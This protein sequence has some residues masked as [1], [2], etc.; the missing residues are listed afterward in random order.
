MGE[1]DI[2]FRKYIKKITYGLYSPPSANTAMSELVN[3]YAE[4][5]HGTL[6]SRIKGH[7]KNFSFWRSVP[8]GTV[9]YRTRPREM[10]YF[11]RLLMKKKCVGTRVGILAS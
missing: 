2:Y 3:V 11:F 7:F 6:I 9:P 8:Y 1:N 10:A 5:E 4:T